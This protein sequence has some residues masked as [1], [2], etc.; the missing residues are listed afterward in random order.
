MKIAITGATG[1]LG[2]AIARALASDGFEVCALGRRPAAVPAIEFKEWDAL[3]GEPP[4]GALAGATAVVHL[5]GEPVAQ[6]WNE[7]VKRRIRD[8]RVAGTRNLVAGL[9]R[10]DPRPEVLVSASAV[11]IY[12]SR[13]EE[14]LTEDAP[15]GTGFLPEVCQAW[16]AEAQGASILGIRVVILRIGMVLGPGGGALKAMLMPFR[17]GL[18]GPLGSGRQ[19][20]P[21]IHIDDVVGLVRFAIRTP[22]LSGPVNATA[23]SPVRN[24]DFSRA[25]GRA[26]RRPAVLPVPEF[27]IRLLYGE[28]AEIVLAS[29]RVLPRKALA[30]GYA[31][32]RQ[33]L[34]AA[35]RDVLSTR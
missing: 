23:P 1:F 24:R 12:G 22:G 33:D 9:A 31:F 2:A 14:T 11:G 34:D 29:Q 28:M 15:P 10:L 20:L 19:W 30:A 18:G 6:R 5:A 21:W 32:R 13:G 7:E 25:L 35:L 26:L 3:R 27:A 8:S 16:E 4:A 17:L